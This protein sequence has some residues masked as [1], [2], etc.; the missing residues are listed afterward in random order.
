MYILV[1]IKNASENRVV[2][3]LNALILI[4]RDGV[5]DHIADMHTSV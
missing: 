3:R 5:Q 1:K 2:P 4:V